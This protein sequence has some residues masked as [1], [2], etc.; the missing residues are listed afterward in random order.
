MF[1]KKQNLD[2]LLMFKHL[3]IKVTISSIETLICFLQSK[4]LI[5][6]KRYK[7]WRLIVLKKCFGAEKSN[8]GVEYDAPDVIPILLHLIIRI[9][10]G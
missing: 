9:W 4:T 7:I 2:A 5:S 6:I 8:L 1:K 3:F 10:I